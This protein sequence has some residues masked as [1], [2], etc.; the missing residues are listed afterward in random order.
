MEI[1]PMTNDLEC[2]QAK[3][4]LAGDRL[5]LVPYCIKRF[6]NDIKSVSS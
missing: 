5:T 3:L 4:P 1:I 6:N 2:Q